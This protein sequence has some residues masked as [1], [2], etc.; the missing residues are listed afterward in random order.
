VLK[1]RQTMQLDHS[2]KSEN[3]IKKAIQQKTYEISSKM[4]SNLWD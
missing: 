2:R 1:T 3:D 4:P